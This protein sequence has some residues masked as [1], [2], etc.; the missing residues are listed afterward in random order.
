MAR[1]VETKIT[2]SAGQ[3]AGTTAI[4]T[5]ETGVVGTRGNVIIGNPGVTAANL[6]MSTGQTH[7]TGLPLAAGAL[8]AFDGELAG[9]DGALFVTGLAAG[10]KMT[11]WIA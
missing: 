9:Y 8:L 6:H 7:G 2:L 3:A 5:A 11:L 4:L 1:W 10:D